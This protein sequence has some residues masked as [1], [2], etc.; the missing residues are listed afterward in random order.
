MWEQN[1]AEHARCGVSHFGDMQIPP[2]S[3]PGECRPDGPTRL[4]V[5]RQSL[6]WQQYLRS[7]RGTEQVGAICDGDLNM[8]RLSPVPRKLNKFKLHRWIQR[9]ATNF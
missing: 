8:T 9:R 3:S 6:I 4:M 5:V 7:N 2:L 1:Y